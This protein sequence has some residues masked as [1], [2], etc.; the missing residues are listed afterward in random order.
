MMFASKVA[1]PACMSPDMIKPCRQVIQAAQ[2]GQQ[3]LLSQH[4]APSVAHVATAHTATLGQGHN[5]LCFTVQNMNRTEP[6]GVGCGLFTH[7]VL[8]MCLLQIC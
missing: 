3:V 4:V 8:Q 1:S 2:Q 6:V 7:C 5:S